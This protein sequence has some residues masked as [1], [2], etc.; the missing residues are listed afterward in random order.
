MP[1]KG[2][3]QANGHVVAGHVDANM[4]A[5]SVARGMIEARQVKGRSGGISLRRQRVALHANLVVLPQGYFECHVYQVTVA[6]FIQ[7]Q[8]EKFEL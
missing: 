2:G 4:A 3:G 8:L 5:I 7:R 6:R 1:Y